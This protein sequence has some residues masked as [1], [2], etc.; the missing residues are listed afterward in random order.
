MIL[1]KSHAIHVIQQQP[2]YSL[3]LRL[4]CAIGEDFPKKTDF[5]KVALEEIK[6]AQNHLNERPRKVLD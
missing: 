2:F 1:E 4:F 5:S 3:H 6:F